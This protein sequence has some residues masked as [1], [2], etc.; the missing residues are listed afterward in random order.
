V[1]FLAEKNIALAVSKDDAC[2]WDATTGKQIFFPCI[3]STQ[4]GS[5]LHASTNHK[6]IY[7][8][9]VSISKK[10]SNL[11]QMWDVSTGKPVFR[12]QLMGFSNIYFSDDGGKVLATGQ[13]G[14]GRML[15]LSTGVYGPSIDFGSKG[16]VVNIA[17]SVGGKLLVFVDESGESQLWDGR[18]GK[19]IAPLRK[20]AKMGR[21]Y[22]SRA[23]I[24]FDARRVM[25]ASFDREKKINIVTTW[26][27]DDNHAVRHLRTIEI[28]TDRDSPANFQFSQ[29]AR[30]LIALTHGPV[31]IWDLE[32]DKLPETFGF[33]VETGSE[34]WSGGR[35]FGK[36]HD[37][38]K[39]TT[40]YLFDGLSGEP[41]ID[42][43]KLPEYV[44]AADI[45][46]DLSFII[47][48]N[49]WHA[50]KIFE[51]RATPIEEDQSGRSLLGV[52]CEKIISQ[53][54]FSDPEV[55][56]IC[57]VTVGGKTSRAAT[58]FAHLPAFR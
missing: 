52:A 50:V 54:E 1:G 23:A 58:K 25:V 10:E 31:Q 34:L 26:T 7:T 40:I 5:W 17:I 6:W 20:S 24:S 46:P 47:V 35:I 29:D 4:E 28:P 43:F 12:Q 53:P 13:G 49:Q 45:S 33:P 39:S 9:R 15:D 42:G 22:L 21:P 3:R 55:A 36:K 32:S 11:V 30:K 16:N 27:I 8:Q 38:D 18:S 44:V 19:L 56:N 37:D 57:G 2:V 48:L 51:L 14:K 41:Q